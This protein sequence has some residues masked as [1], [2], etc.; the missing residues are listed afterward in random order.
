MVATIATATLYGLVNGWLGADGWF[1]ANK[2]DEKTRFRAPHS[3]DELARLC[4]DNGVRDVYPHLTPTQSNGAMSDHDDAQIER[5]LDRTNGC[6][7]CPGLA[8]AWTNTSRRTMPPKQ[9]ASCN[10]L[11]T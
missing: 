8:G 1:D 7:F 5:L 6:A 10:R 3:I 11:V 2:P 4:R 9:R